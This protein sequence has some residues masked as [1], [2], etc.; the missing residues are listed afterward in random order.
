MVFAWNEPNL[1]RLFMRFSFDIGRIRIRLLKEAKHGHH[2]LEIRES[3]IA[4]S[5]K[6]VCYH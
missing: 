4:T 2:S 6:G 1:V 3:I 5:T